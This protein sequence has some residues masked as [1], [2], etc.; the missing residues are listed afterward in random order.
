MNLMNGTNSF[1]LEN[2]MNTKGKILI[3]DVPKGEMTQTYEYYIR[4]ILEYILGL[5]LNR[6]KIRKED[7]ILTHLFLDEFHNFV[8]SN[9]NIKTILTEVGK[10]NFFLT[11]AHQTISQIP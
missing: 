1:N 6:V 9:N 7:R 11:M 4:F 8:S 2:E 5:V 10:Y 3:F